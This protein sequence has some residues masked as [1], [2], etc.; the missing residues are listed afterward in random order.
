MNLFLRDDVLKDP[1]TYVREIFKYGFQ[2]V[3]DGVNNFK[4]IQPR[5]HQDEFA[6]Y[7]LSFFSGYEIAWNFVRQSPY[8]QLEPNYVH[9]DEMMGDITCILYLNEYT[10]S[11]DGTTMYDSNGV[12]AC[13]VSSK[14]NRM[15][16]FNSI[17]PHSRNIFENF[18]EGE[19]ARLI[20][21]IF[22]RKIR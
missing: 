5:D 2:D 13:I 15:I 19:N 16:A 22:L 17:T 7:V 14:F 3:S 12:V 6:E 9:T 4:G 11:A 21:V 18:G 10:P 1:H 8:G 20:Q